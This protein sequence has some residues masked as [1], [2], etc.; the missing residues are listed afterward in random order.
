MGRELGRRPTEKGIALTR[1]TRRTTPSLWQASSRRNIGALD[2]PP[3]QWT[4][5][6]RQQESMLRRGANRRLGRKLLIEH[7]MGDRMLSTLGR[8]AFLPTPNIS[9]I[10]GPPKAWSGPASEARQRDALFS[11]SPA[12]HSPNSRPPFGKHVETFRISLQDSARPQMS[13][14]DIA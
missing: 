9:P 11:W 13:L 10:G 5:R 2:L 12:Q 14:S 8:G 4:G 6:R 3:P 7:N 1:L